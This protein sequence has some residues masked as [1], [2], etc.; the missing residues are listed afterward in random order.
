M[1]PWEWT[2]EQDALLRVGYGRRPLDELALAIGRGPKWLIV[3]ARRLHLRM[4]DAFTPAERD[5]VRRHYDS[6][7]R[8]ALSVLR[9]QLG[10]SQITLRRLA[11]IVQGEIVAADDWTAEDEAWLRA[12]WLRLPVPQ[13]AEHLQRT[14]SAV[15]KHA[16]LRGLPYRPEHGRCSV[17]ATAQLLGVNRFAVL[18][19][20]QRGLMGRRSGKSR[21]VILPGD[22]PTFLRDYRLD[23]DWQDIQPSSPYREL[24]RRLEEADPY[25]TLT[26]VAAHYRLKHRATVASWVKRGILPSVLGLRRTCDGHQRTM[27]TLIRQRDLSRIDAWLVGRQGRA[28][29]P[30]LRT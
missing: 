23:Y 28:G 27:V 16:Y 12:E 11:R 7:D 30:V 9:A 15:R 1:M 24:A 17:H 25:W 19:W 13:L 21:W 6:Q 26:A 29:R 14:P 3:R 20:C 18:D 8:T 22:L 4:D 2:E 5:L 10:V